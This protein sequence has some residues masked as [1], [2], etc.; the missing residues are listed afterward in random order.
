MSVVPVS[1]YFVPLE[2]YLETER[3][4][5]ARHEYLAGAVY[6]MAG[7]GE[8]HNIIAV[9]LLTLL[10]VALRD[11]RCQPFGSDMQLRLSPL[12]ATYCYYPDAMISCDPAEASRGW[13]EHPAAIFE[14]LSPGTRRIDEGEKQ[15]IYLQVRS[16]QAY[17][18]IEPGSPHVTMERRTPEGWRTDRV[19][20]LGSAVTIEVAGYP[21]TFPLAEL[22]RRVVF[23]TEPPAA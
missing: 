1:P 21:I 18:R 11:S 13:R 6:A 12:G 4:A 22:Y 2:E 19:V 14:I 10:N 15:I 8:A 3:A 5:E 23:E 20:G 16:L 17:L 9:N 7:A